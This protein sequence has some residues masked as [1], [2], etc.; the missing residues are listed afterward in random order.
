M[1]EVLSNVTRV[2]EENTNTSGGPRSLISASLPKWVTVEDILHAVV[3]NNSVII[4][5]NHTFRYALLSYCILGECREVKGTVSLGQYTITLQAPPK[6]ITTTGGQL[7][8]VLIRKEG[9]LVGNVSHY[10]IP[11]L[12]SN[13]WVTITMSAVN[14]SD[15][16]VMYFLQVYGLPTQGFTKMFSAWLAL[17]PIA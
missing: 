13:Y 7:T 4:I 1:K 2:L 11:F 14:L 3:V 6:T 17:V 8:Y 9:K 15:N 10:Y 12:I 5:G 16:H